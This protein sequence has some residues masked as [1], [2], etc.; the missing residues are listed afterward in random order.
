MENNWKIVD[1]SFQI[2]KSGRKRYY[3]LIECK[4]SAQ[5][6]VWTSEWTRFLEKRHKA[7]LNIQCRKCALDQYWS[8]HTEQDS[9]KTLWL[10]LKTACK[11]IERDFS[12]T[13][14]KAFVLHKSNCFY[15]GAPPSNTFTYTTNTSVSFIY[16]G[17]DR[18]NSDK[19]Y[20]ED[21]VVACCKICNVM[22]NNLPLEEFLAHI[23]SI[24]INC[25]QRLSERSEYAQVSGNKRLPE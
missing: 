25:V 19:G 18:I 12:I 10:N 5:R 11:R 15:C 3:H 4:C 13:K 8:K 14:E 23:N 7:N 24:Y 22:K 2:L 16:S 9:S 17:I 21:N 1:T 6:K 20:T